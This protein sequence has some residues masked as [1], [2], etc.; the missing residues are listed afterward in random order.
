[1]NKTERIKKYAKE[2]GFDD[3]GIV[4]AKLLSQEAKHLNSWLEKK[5]N[6]DMHYMKKNIDKR[7]NPKLLVPNAKSIII[8]LKNYFPKKTQNKNSFLI[9][10]YAYG[11]DYHKILKKDLKKLYNFIND[12]IE[13]I[14]G[15]IFVDS[16]P[17]L[18]KI[19]AQKA[20]LGWIGKNS[21]LITKKGSF[22]FIGEIICDIELQY[23]SSEMK[24]YCG[25]CSKCIDNCPTNAI[26]PN[27]TINSNKCISYLTIE[28]KDNFDPNMNLNFKNFIFGCDICQDVCPW[29]SK[30]QASNDPRLEPHFLLL[31]LKK[32]DWKNLSIDTFNT[33]FKHSAVKRT[34]YNG[35]LRNIR[36]VSNS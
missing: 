9:S 6:A 13:P 22:F 35:L 26:M 21:L 30:S 1:L 3:I 4:E 34:K 29:N 28:K 33:I 14:N 31:E 10:K 36:Y 19:W 15:R 7:L 18:E 16:A 20:G 8:V 12:N 25:S 2:L 32:N 5:Y 11:T 23:N 17:V 27:K 24:N